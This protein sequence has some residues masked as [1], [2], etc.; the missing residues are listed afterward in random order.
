VT[1]RE[2]RGT[3]VST[4]RLQLEPR[5][6][7]HDAAAQAGHFAAL[8][9]THLYLSPILQAS[10]GSTH[11]YDVVDHSRVAEDLGGEDGFRALVA[12]AHAEGLGIV[13]DV[14]PNH[15][16][17]PTPLSRNAALWSVLREGR[18]SPYAAWF[19]VDW[20]AQGGRLLMPV[21]GGPLSAVLAAGEL[22]LGEHEGEPVVRY[23]DHVFPVSPGTERRPLG[24]LL[25]A[26]HYRLADWRL[27][28]TELNYR[29]F[30]DVTSLIAVRVE[31]PEVFDAT[32][33]HLVE[34]VRDGSIDGLRI[35]HPDGLADP[36][37]YLA[38]LADQ[39]GG[40]W[41]VVEKILEG[42]ETLP[43]GWACAGTTGYDALLRVGGLF[44]DPHGEHALTALSE[45]LLG[46]RQDLETM[47]TEAKAYVVDNVLE[48]EVNRLLRLVAATRPE[49]DHDAA[50]RGIEALL[51]AMD[52]YRAYLRPGEPADAEQVAVVQQA[53]ERAQRQLPAGDHAALAGLV[54]L[55]LGQGVSAGTPEAD[56][57][58]V[59]FQQ[60]CGP[61]MAKGIEDTTFYRHVR[62][63]SL[64]EVGGDPAR[65]GLAPKEFHEFCEGLVRDWPTTMTTLSTHDTKRSEDVRARL[66]VLAERPEAWAKWLRE[67]RRIAERYCSSSVDPATEYLLWQA[68]VGAWPLTTERLAAYALKATKEAKQH[69]SWTDP[70]PDYEA[71][72]EG[73]VTG[74]VEDPEIAERV[75]QWHVATA[76]ESRAAILGQKLVQLTMP[77]VPDAYQGAELVDLS[78]VDPDNRRP[79]DHAGHAGRLARLDAGEPPRDLS[80]EKLLV[81][82]QALRL[83][84]DRPGAFIGADTAH[85]PLAT[86]SEHLVAY[87]RGRA[88]APEVA[89]LATRLAGRLDDAGG[90]GEATVTLP[91]GEW[92]DLL[93]GRSIRG[94]SRA[95]GTLLPDG[96]LPVALLTKE[97]ETG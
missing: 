39:T 46:E 45:E 18:E 24:E 85:V 31:L 74:I 50:L 88:R 73:F 32:H 23:F 35:D 10:A 61:V 87:A 38:R 17:T 20:E 14:V 66:A 80:D 16:T 2:G 76:R 62:L 71:A 75:E 12:A 83:R 48:A 96:G 69:T 7:L 67:S 59:R 25:D 78:L 22:S 64:N 30:F 9:V 77:G 56:D 65:I 97:K 93:T 13:V 44:V 49:L 4:L 86:T 1:G 94:G 90:W 68:L 91:D 15:M 58:L 92:N 34:L 6:T 53:A 82:T 28:G 47:V 37:G 63:T 52:R 54:E 42:H 72:V 36:E 26:Q 41:V 19:D 29:R 57:F 95:V 21:L 43:R 79:V 70:D 27:G 51:V 60:T 5:F 84:R 55:A 81:T 8:G 3:P 40:A 89:V 11:G 33:A